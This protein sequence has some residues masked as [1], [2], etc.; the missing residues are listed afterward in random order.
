MYEMGTVVFVAL[1]ISLH[2]KIAFMHQ[3]WNKIHV[4][5]MAFSV[6]MLFLVMYIMNLSLEEF[7]YYGVVNFTYSQGIFWFFGCFTIPLVCYLTDV[8]GSSMYLFFMASYEIIG[9]VGPSA[10][11]L[12]S[13]PE[14]IYREK[15]FHY[16]Q[17]NSWW[18]AW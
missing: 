5:S 12:L 17:K 10:Y 7:D 2:C 11:W 1:I 18:E 14:A 16:D 13:S 3:V 4:Y 8:V 9:K 15:A 6:G